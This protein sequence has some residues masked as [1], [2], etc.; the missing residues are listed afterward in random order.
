MSTRHPLDQTLPGREALVRRTL[1]Y[2]AEHKCMSLATDGPEGLWAAT[3]FYVNEAFELYFLSRCD[4]RHVRNIEASPRV[5]ATISDDVAHWLGI[6]GIQLEGTAEVVGASRRG[7]AL[8]AFE[9]RYAFADS[10]WWTESP[11]AAG[12]QQL[13]FCVRP[14]RM[15]FLDHGFRDRR[16]EIPADYLRGRPARAP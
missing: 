11:S 16:A 1:E 13:V 10:L 9:R 12:P 8:A 2:L 6:R 15:L 5:A 7:A 14:T 3:V 4:T